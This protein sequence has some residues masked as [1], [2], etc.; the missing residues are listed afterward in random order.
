MNHEDAFSPLNSVENRVSGQKRPSA[1]SYPARLRIRE[2]HE[3]DF[4]WIETSLNT[5]VQKR[6]E[7]TRLPGI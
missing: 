5:A 7:L 2:N 4:P 6:A 3:L 1:R